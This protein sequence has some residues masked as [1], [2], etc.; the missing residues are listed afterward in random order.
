MKWGRSTEC[1]LR[2]EAKRKSKFFKTTLVP[3]SA[4]S[5]ASI[6]DWNAKIQKLSPLE[7]VLKRP[8]SYVGSIETTRQPM[9]VAERTGTSGAAAAADPVD[10]VEEVPSS[11]DSTAASSSSSSLFRLVR[12]EVSFNAA[13]IKIGDELIVNAYDHARRTAGFRGAMKLTQIDVK[14]NPVGA[15]DPV[16]GDEL[17]MLEI[18]NNGQG[19]AI[20]K[21]DKYNAFHHQLVFGELMTGTNFDDMETR[22]VGGRNGLGCKLTNIFSR[23]FEV[24][25]VDST[26]KKCILL[27]FRNNMTS[28]EISHPKY[29]KGSK[30]L[31]RIRVWP[32]FSRFTFYDP[33]RDWEDTEAMLLRRLI[34][35]AL[36]CPSYVKITVNGDVLPHS[37][38]A[39]CDALIQADES[40]TPVFLSG[41]FGQAALFPSEWLHG[42]HAG[43]D[44]ETQVSF[45]HLSL[46][47]GICTL[48]GGTHVDAVSNQVVNTLFEWFQKK[49]K[50]DTH[51]ARV[52]KKWVKDQFCLVLNSIVGNPSFDS[53]SKNKLMTKVPAD[54]VVSIPPKAMQ[55]I[56]NWPLWENLL[57]RVQERDEKKSNESTRRFRGM[58]TGIP[59]LS[60]APKAGTKDWQ[61]CRLFLVEGL[62]ART[63][64]LSGFAALPESERPYYGVYALRGKCL[65]TRDAPLSSVMNNTEMQQIRQILGVPWKLPVVA[66]ATSSSATATP[67]L[68]LRYGQVVFFT[69]QDLDGFHIRGLL[70][71]LFDTLWPRILHSNDSLFAFQTP[72]VKIFRG[73]EIVH[74]FLDQESFHRWKSSQSESSMKSLTVKYYK[75]LGTSSQSEAQQYFRQLPRF[76]QVFS[77]DQE[78]ST[79]LSLAFDKTKAD[80]RKSW[81]QSFEAASLDPA[82][83]STTAS[84]SSSSS[85]P[86]DTSPSS[87]SASTLD[88]YFAPSTTASSTSMTTTGKRKASSKSAAAPVYPTLPPMP[89]STFVHTQLAQFSYYNVCRSIPS[90]IDGLKIST[91]KILF[92]C[93]KRRI[94]KDMKVSQ[95]AGQVM[96]DAAYHHGESSLMDAVIGLAQDFV[97]SNN[98]NLLTPSG[99]FGSRL[100][101]GHDAAAPRYLHTRLMPHTTLLFDSRDESLLKYLDDD[102][103]PIEPQQFVPLLPMVL[104][105]GADGIATGFSSSVPPHRPR[106]VIQNVRQVLSGAEPT[107]MVPWYRG[108]TGTVEAA[109]AG[110]VVSSGSWRIRGRFARTAPDTL[111]LSELP[112]GTWT[113]SYEDSIKVT[114]PSAASTDSV[115]KRKTSSSNGG[116]V[117]APPAILTTSSSSSSNRPLTVKQAREHI[118]RVV[119]HDHVHLVNIEVV[120]DRPDLLDQVLAQD[121]GQFV[122]K[123]LKLETNVHTQNMYLFD[124]NYRVR[125][126]ADTAEILTS[127]VHVRLALYATRKAHLL[128]VWSA[129]L[130]EL[131]E[132]LRFLSLNIKR[133]WE[134]Y[135][136]GRAQI[137]QEL[138]ALQFAPLPA[139]PEGDLS[140]DYLLHIRVD[141]YT[142]ERMETLQARK[143]AKEADVLVLQSKSP[144]DLYR[145]DLDALES[146]LQSSGLL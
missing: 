98:I 64:C 67:D 120:F 63:A 79:A 37:M 47:N 90:S 107:P 28:C 38:A 89:M 134:P 133:Q 99:Q 46:V 146:T 20:E 95:L 140:W 30:D 11:I 57:G 2:I 113:S 27:T 132:T 49:F 18:A 58:M 72:L 50:S 80:Q 121:D 116:E 13:V 48:D 39:Y 22:T 111:T 44:H 102:G 103:K 4:S 36:I 60:D 88:S 105:N 59:H 84:S 93:L 56:A 143:E 131:T 65:N 66:A 32:D 19:I 75:G 74:E 45:Q 117:A 6:V 41:A 14:M 3:M 8:D 76:M 53:Q 92:T 106:D 139:S 33:A 100:E 142:K 141:Q 61:K 127:A 87:A 16:T 54:W 110:D 118:V 136:K 94:T 115:K 7:H 42:G 91:R 124:E 86:N 70:L 83:S 17:P 77:V 62:S 135:H 71:N 31:T 23:R 119:R 69:D 125:K 126:F 26:N 40:R 5:P 108:F 104:I 137:I 52:Q 128:R 109:A 123:V 73:T 9:W 25:G 114:E 145:D 15:V 35:G 12:R 122:W 78:A 85:F 81:I 96:A 29:E 55:E 1:F 43:V 51:A 24:Y 34:D 130:H 138:T 129:E 68:T 144:E 97:G 21:H 112:I 10:M 82:S 101:G